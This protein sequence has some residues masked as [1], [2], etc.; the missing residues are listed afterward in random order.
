MTKTEICVLIALVLLIGFLLMVNEAVA[1]R[2]C[3]MRT[4]KYWSPTHQA[5]VTLRYWDCPSYAQPRTMYSR[6]RTWR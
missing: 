5:Y 4:T 2:A 6:H 3:I 1:Q